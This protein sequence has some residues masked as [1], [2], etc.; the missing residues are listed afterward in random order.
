MDRIAERAEAAI[1]QMPDYE[2]YGRVTKVLG[3]LVEIAGFA[4]RTWSSVRTFI[5][6]PGPASTS[7]AK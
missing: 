6:G 4:D 5:C 1:S 3:L 7:P 2:V